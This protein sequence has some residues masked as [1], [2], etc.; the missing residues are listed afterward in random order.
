VG[1]GSQIW[2]SVWYTK[3]K[4]NTKKKTKC[5]KEDAFHLRTPT[6]AEGRGVIED[7]HDPGR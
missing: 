7:R 5:K 2:W 1:K 4:E 6:S 3:S